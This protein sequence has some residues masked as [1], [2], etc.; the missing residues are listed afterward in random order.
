MAESTARQMIREWWRQALDGQES[1]DLK[2]FAK[3]GAGELLNDPDFRE[4]FLGEFVYSAVYE[5]GMRI[6]ATN[7]TYIRS[8]DNFKTRDQWSKEIRD[9][10]ADEDVSKT[11]AAWLEYD[12]ISKINIA[13]PMMTKAQLLAAAQ[14]RREQGR[15]ELVDGEW[16]ALLAGR[17][18]DDQ[19]ASDVWTEADAMKIREN[20]QIDTTVSLK[21]VNKRLTRKAA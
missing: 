20:I 5:S 12:P 8:G 11:W 14:R 10:A 21:G 15:Q 2:A 13:I 19:V 18:N 6:L 1:V 4:A 9:E 7:R 17:M 3:E 16:F